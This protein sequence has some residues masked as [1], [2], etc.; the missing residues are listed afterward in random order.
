MGL[1]N[2]LKVYYNIFLRIDVKFYD[3]I[4]MVRIYQEESID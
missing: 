1:L 2:W 3:W 4:Q